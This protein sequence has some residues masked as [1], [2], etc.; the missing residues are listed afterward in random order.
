MSIYTYMVD[1]EKFLINT[2]YVEIK[3]V[4]LQQGSDLIWWGARYV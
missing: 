3:R 1:E 2:R 4:S